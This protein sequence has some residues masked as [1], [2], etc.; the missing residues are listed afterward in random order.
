MTPSTVG[1]EATTEASRIFDDANQTS[2]LNFTGVD[3][4]GL[5]DEGELLFYFVWWLEKDFSLHSD[6]VRQS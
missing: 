5:L 6:V 4:G 1:G 2:L 3:H